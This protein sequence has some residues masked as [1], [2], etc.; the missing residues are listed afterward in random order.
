MREKFKFA[1]SQMNNNTWNFQ[2]KNTQFVLKV[3]YYLRIMSNDKHVKQYLVYCNDEVYRTLYNPNV[4]SL[5]LTEL[6]C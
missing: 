1:Y 2:M 3:Q 6:K 5:K 4:P